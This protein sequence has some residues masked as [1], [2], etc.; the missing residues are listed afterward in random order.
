MANQL[1]TI[2]TNPKIW[3]LPLEDDGLPYVA[4]NRKETGVTGD[5]WTEFVTNVE[6][7]FF[8]IDIP[9]EGLFLCVREFVNFE[10]NRFLIFI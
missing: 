10:E 4:Y 2:L 3:R 1:G 8:D 5:M 9:G 6:E 7:K